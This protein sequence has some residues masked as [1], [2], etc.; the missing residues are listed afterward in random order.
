VPRPASVISPEEALLPFLF[1]KGKREAKRILAQNHGY[2]YSGQTLTGIVVF[3]SL[4]DWRPHLCIVEN[5]TLTRLG[6]IL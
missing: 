1:Y 6:H 5:A 3:L 2:S 4:R